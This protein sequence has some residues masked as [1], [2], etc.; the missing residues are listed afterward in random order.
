MLSSLPESNFWMLLLCRQKSTT[1]I[2]IVVTMRGIAC[3]TKK[4][5]KTGAKAVAMRAASDE[6]LNTL[7]TINQVAAVAKPTHHEKPNKTPS[8]VATPLPPLKP[9]KTGNKCPAKAAAPVRA[10]V[11]G[12]NSN[13]LAT[14]TG[15]KPFSISPNKVIAAGLLPP[16]RSTLVAPGLPE[17]WVRGSGR[18]ITLQTIMAVE[19]EPSK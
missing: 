4:Y 17:P 7:A 6:S 15:S 10:I 19:I 13:V 12:P 3:G 18:R 14:K 11:R 2:P 9:K 1:T 5:K 16:T 8:N